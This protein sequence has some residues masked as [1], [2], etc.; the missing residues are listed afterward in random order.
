MPD[1]LIYVTQA[2]V[3]L[4]FFFGILKSARYEWG[5]SVKVP[6]IIRDERNI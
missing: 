6:G 3:C 1:E 4:G 2:G 5:K